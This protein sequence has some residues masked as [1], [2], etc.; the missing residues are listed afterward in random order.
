MK[1]QNGPPSD[2][3]TS[4]LF[5]CTKTNELILNNKRKQ[6]VHRMAQNGMVL[7]EPTKTEE[8]KKNFQNSTP[9]N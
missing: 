3:Q 2:N 7:K 1:W 4:V 8:R 9:N 6:T 5:F